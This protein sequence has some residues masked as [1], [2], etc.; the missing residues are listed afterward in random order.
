MPLYHISWSINR[1]FGV[2]R[3][4]ISV[5]SFCA[6]CNVGLLE[7]RFYYVITASKNTEF[8]IGFIQIRR[9]QNA[10]YSG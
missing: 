8:N 7:H 10:L 2:I 6:H 5:P 9:A 1:T 4:R 3:H